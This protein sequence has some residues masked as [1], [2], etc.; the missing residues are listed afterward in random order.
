LLLLSCK[1]IDVK[2]R[3]QH[4]HR[5]AFDETRLAE[6]K[7]LPPLSTAK[8]ESDS[9]K[10][11][12]SGRVAIAPVKLQPAYDVLAIQMINDEGRT[13]TYVNE[14]WAAGIDD[15][16]R[17]FLTS[18]LAYALKND[19][20]DADDPRYL[21]ECE[22][23]EMRADRTKVDLLTMITLKTV[24]GRRETVVW[25][26]VVPATNTLPA[27]G[28][29]MTVPAAYERALADI[30]AEILLQIRAQDPKLQS[31]RRRAR[32]AA[33]EARRRADVAL[34]RAEQEKA[35]ADAAKAR[36]DAAIDQV[37]LEIA[38][39]QASEARARAAKAEAEAAK[40]RAEAD[41]AEA[42]AGRRP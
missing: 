24:E 27:N 21:V 42:E 11:L 34:V 40:A 26:G 8:K 6:A 41:K 9:S 5:I 19:L 4:I 35:R 31:E 28:N 25:T 12:G 10:A 7:K 17:A 29:Y 16:A 36:L 20:V 32:E 13:D 3:C 30:G 22:I 14:C 37:E 15:M 23:V 2:P 39:A 1:G 33:A 18:Y 38:R